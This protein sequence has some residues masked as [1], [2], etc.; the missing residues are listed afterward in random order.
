[1]AISECP[2]CTFHIALQSGAEVG[3]AIECP[4]CGAPLKV[5]SLFPPIFEKI[6]ED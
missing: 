2:E 1:M 4:D 6:G 5:I 3:A